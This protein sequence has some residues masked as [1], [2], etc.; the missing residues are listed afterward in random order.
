MSGTSK[1]T[2][3][4]AIL[5]AAVSAFAVT[6][7][8]PLREN[9]SRLLGLKSPGASWRL[10]AILLALANVKNLPFVWHVSTVSYVLYASL[11]RVLTL[12]DPPLSRLNLPYLVPADTTNSGSTLQIL[13]YSLPCAALGNRLQPS[14]IE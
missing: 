2:R 14:Q 5:G 10:A 1:A 9:I 8:G 7:N 4:A 3:V 6:A 12:S 13:Y 11:G